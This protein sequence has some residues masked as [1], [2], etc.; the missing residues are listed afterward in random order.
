MMGKDCEQRK[1]HLLAN[2]VVR[3]DLGNQLAGEVLMPEQCF[4]FASYRWVILRMSSCWT[5]AILSSE[6]QAHRLSVLCCAQLI[7][8][9][10][11]NNTQGRGHKRLLRNLPVK[12]TRSK[13]S[14]RRP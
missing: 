13:T 8:C 7:V 12:D 5:G 11:E 6:E 2:G 1:T 14:E 4:A 9:Q 10:D 3:F